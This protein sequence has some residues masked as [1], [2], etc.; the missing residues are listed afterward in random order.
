M[1]TSAKSAPLCSS[2]VSYGALAQDLQHTHEHVYHNELSAPVIK[3]PYHWY[4]LGAETTAFE[5]EYVDDHSWEDLQE[6]EQGHLRA[7]VGVHR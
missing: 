7:L 4:R 5:R 6:D 1:R 2:C 3:G